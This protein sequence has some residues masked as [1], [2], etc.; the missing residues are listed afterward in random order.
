MPEGAPEGCTVAAPSPS[1]TVRRA[2]AAAVGRLRAA[3]IVGATLDA[4]LLLA[5][6]MGRARGRLL[7][8]D[9]EPLAGAAAGRFERH[10]ARRLAH[11][12]V[13]RIL[14]RREFWSLELEI[15][16]AVLDPRP[17]SETLVEAALAAARGRAG[18]VTIADLGTGSGCLLLALLSELDGAFGVGVDRDA[19]VLDVARR[20]A[21]RT[22]LGG[23]AAFVAADWGA[24]LGSRFDIVLCNPPYLAR[25]ELATAAAELRHD[26]RLALAGGE[27]GLDAYRA[28]LP[29]LP[30]CL[31]GGGRAFLEIGAAQARAVG[32]IVAGAGL[33]VEAV[34]SDLAGRDRCIV[35]RSG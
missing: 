19:A 6:A 29:G 30:A 24:A 32:T 1:P 20:N 31:A 16:P 3:G 23:R 35:A 5:D 10:L 18:H 17:D 11:E 27:D 9:A 2:L 26:P 33:E 22:G 12:P 14:G 13:S 8:N 4:E 25:R 15:S 21:L 7:A 34:V 28:L